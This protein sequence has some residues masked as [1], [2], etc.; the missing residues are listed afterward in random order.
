M[1]VTG[2]YLIDS[3]RPMSGLYIPCLVSSRLIA[4]L[5]RVV[6]VIDFVNMLGIARSSRKTNQKDV[7]EIGVLSIP[8]MVA[9]SPNPSVYETE[10]GGS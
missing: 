2:G 8:I 6:Y 7:K 1:Q 3:S 5:S 9:C 4:V 10:A